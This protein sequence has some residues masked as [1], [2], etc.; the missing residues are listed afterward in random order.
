MTKAAAKPNTETIDLEYVPR[1][2]QAHV[3]KTRKRYSVWVLHRRAGKTVALVMEAI[4][5]ALE[6]TGHAPRVALIY[7]WRT[8]AETVAWPILEMVA[9]KIPDARATRSK[10]EVYFPHNDA[11]IRCFGTH[12]GQYESM[13]GLYFDLAC[14]DE[15]AQCDAKAL[16]EV[17]RPALSDHKGELIICGT[18]KGRD[19]FYKEWMAAGSLPDLWSRFM[20]KASESGIIDEQELSENRA[21]LDQDVYDREYE[22]EFSAVAEGAFYTNQIRDLRGEGR[23]TELL[24]IPNKPVGCAVDIGISDA[25]VCWFFQVIGTAVHVI[26]CQFWHDTKIQDILRDIRSQ[27][28]NLMVMGIPHDMAQRDQLT[29]MTK[30]MTFREMLPGVEVVLLPRF[31]VDTGIMLVRKM[32]GQIK[33]DAAHCGDGLGYLSSYVRKFSRETNQFLNTPKHDAASDYADAF[34]YL[35]QLLDVQAG[36]DG[37]GNGGTIDETC[38]TVMH[39]RPKVV[40]RFRR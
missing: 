36:G 16:P 8:Q 10:L 27:E 7:P 2:W 3:H 31:A 4:R 17:V 24:P 20:L 38:M 21:M 34:R 22:C 23:L 18:P 14:F 9:R 37:S 5:T 12:D 13:R 30:E 33:M 1:E 28:Y 39:T 26:D 11:V 15:F 40:G 29:G 25:S 32:F 19:N 35:C 6:V